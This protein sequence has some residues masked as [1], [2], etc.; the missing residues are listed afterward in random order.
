MAVTMPVKKEDIAFHVLTKKSAI[1]WKNEHILSHIPI[2]KSLIAVQTSY[3]EVPN[4]PRNTSAVPLSISRIL[5]NVSTKK[6][7]I[8]TKML[9]T[10]FQHCSQSPV[11]RPINT[12]RRL[13][14]VAVTRVKILIYQLTLEL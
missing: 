9:F 7:H 1:D 12:S 13:K 10:P 11:N 3:H 2:K 5:L 4:Q 8:P 6:S 14:I